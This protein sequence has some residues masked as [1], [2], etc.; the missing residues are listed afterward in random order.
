[1]F[2]PNPYLLVGDNKVLMEASPKVGPRII[3]GLS[4]RHCGGKTLQTPFKHF[5]CVTSPHG[6]ASHV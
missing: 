1:M 5:G 4:R 2:E 6:K 3:Y